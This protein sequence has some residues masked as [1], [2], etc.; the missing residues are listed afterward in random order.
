MDGIDVHLTHWMDIS[1]LDEARY[2]KYLRKK[3][4]KPVEMVLKNGSK[5]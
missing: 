3:R 5:P 2:G 4:S 1:F